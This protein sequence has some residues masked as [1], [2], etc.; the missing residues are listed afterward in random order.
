VSKT[1]FSLSAALLLITASG[2]SLEAVAQGG[3]ST[4][5]PVSANVPETCSVSTAN[6]LA[7]GPYDAVATNRLNPLNGEGTIS[8]SCSK[9]AT[10]LQ[11]VMSTGSHEGTNGGR[12]MIGATID[13]NTG[14][15]LFLNY[16]VFQ[17][18]TNTPGEACVFPATIPWTATNPFVIGV[19]N[20]NAPRLFSVCGTIPAGQDAATDSY[21]DVLTAELNF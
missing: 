8:V 14:T 4:Q 21:S 17:P 19:P 16:D 7:F 12:R 13:P 10:G 2:L 3:A 5:I 11:I 15:F 6:T 20:S 18:R 1:A 9:G